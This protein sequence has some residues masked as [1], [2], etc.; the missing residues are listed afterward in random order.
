MKLSED[1]TF[2]Y[3][4]LINLSGQVYLTIPGGMNGKGKVQISVKGANHELTAMTE[5]EKLLSGTSVTVKE[6]RDNILIVIK[7]K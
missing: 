5:G 2:K 1:N 7:T 6:I 3:E 4:N